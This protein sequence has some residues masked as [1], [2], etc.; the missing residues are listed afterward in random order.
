MNSLMLGALLIFFVA[1]LFIASEK[2][3]KTIVALLAA[4]LMIIFH[5]EEQN[6]AFSHVDYN[7]IF[8][9]IGMMLLVK[10]IQQT[11]GFEYIAIKFAKM[12]KGNPYKIMIVL[13]LM[14]ATLSAFLDNITTVLLISPISILIANEMEISPLP[15]LLTQIFA[16]NI[17][18]T[19]T[20][21]GDPPNIMIGSAARL[22]FMDFIVNLTPIILI[23]LIVFSIIFYFLFKG[24]MEVTNESR[25]RIMDFDE[26]KMIKDYP[27]L[28]KSSIVFGAVLIGFVIHGFLDLE[29]SA[30]AFTGGVFLLLIGKL[31]PEEIFQKVEW[32]TIF[33]F[34]GLFI[35]VGALVETGFIDL[36]SKYL[37]NLTRGNIKGTANLVLWFSGVFSAI[38]DN[39]PYVATMI[40]LIQELGHSLGQHTIIPLWWALSL[41]ACLGGNGTLIG[42][43]ANVIISDFAKKSGYPITFISFLKYSVPI[44]ALSLFI[45]YFYIMI[46]YF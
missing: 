38:V 35:M 20:L 12:V 2:I 11:G 18:G 41:G 13:F 26:K 16:S 29:A 30:I 36:I 45:S 7:V 25:A 5:I 37:L 4:F 28:I 21:I 33:F 3:N 9:L 43:S 24:K 14:T 17:G 31:N 23:Q 42:A 34:I 10:I 40:P 22:T 1:Y 46:R 6:A 8:L 44:T 27:L 19:A 39:I 32:V 15:F